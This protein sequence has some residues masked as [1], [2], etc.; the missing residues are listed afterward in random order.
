MYPD[1]NPAPDPLRP[2]HLPTGS[3]SADWCELSERVDELPRRK[4]TL[5]SI[6]YLANLILLGAFVGVFPRYASGTDWSDMRVIWLMVLAAK[7]AI[8]FGHFLAGFHLLRYWLIL[9]AIWI[10][11]GGVLGLQTEAPEARTGYLFLFPIA[12]GFAS[13]LA[14]LV[15]TQFAYYAAANLNN[16]WFVSDAWRCDWNAFADGRRPHHR[17]ELPVMPRAVVA[18]AAAMLIGG[19]FNEWTGFGAVWFLLV[20]LLIAPVFW[21]RGTDPIECLGAGW[22]AW[23]VFLTYERK[24][25]LAPGAFRFPTRWLRPHARRVLALFT[26]IVLASVSVGT[27]LPAKWP[28]PA[29]ASF[30]ERASGPHQTVASAPMTRVELDHYDRIA[31]RGEQEAYLS[32]IRR[33][34]GNEAEQFR[35]EQKNYTR[36]VLT[37][38]VTCVLIPPAVVFGTLVFLFGPALAAYRRNLDGSPQS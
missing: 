2:R 5:M 17:V 10:L 6:R 16:E 11:L 23:E 18:I 8:C 38:G 31:F 35:V 27:M 33:R 12:V 9:T 34:R 24:P 29:S 21:P 7:L 4:A 26:P 1:W 20:L 28:Q 14:F 30:I 15:A 19:I 37:T 3:E 25:C 13:W 22:R 32:F 36:T